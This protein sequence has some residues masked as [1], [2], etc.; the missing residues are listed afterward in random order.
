MFTA[1]GAVVLIAILLFL[2]RALLG[3]TAFDRILAVNAIG[4]K[5]VVFVALLGFMA[6][7]PDFLD[8]ALLYALINFIATLA[9]LKFV[10]YRHLD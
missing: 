8:I 7:R 6:G 1:A 9:V 10:E 4:T 5:T 3:P 2:M